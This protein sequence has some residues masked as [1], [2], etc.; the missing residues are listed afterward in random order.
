MTQDIAKVSADANYFTRIGAWLSER[1]PLANGI[2]SLVL[3]FAVAA[4]MQSGE[5]SLTAWTNWA[6]GM[7]LWGHFFVLRIFDEHKD[8]QTDLRNYPDRVIQSGVVKLREIRLLGYIVVALQIAYSEYRGGGLGFPLYAWAAMFGYT[9]LMGAEFFVGEWLQKRLLVY[10]ATHMLVMPLMAIW[11]CALAGAGGFDERVAVLALLF[12]CAGFAY[13]IFRKIRAPEQE[14]AG[15]DTYSSILGFRSASALA[16]AFTSGFLL[17]A[18]ALL[19]WA[20][21]PSAAAVALAIFLVLH[22]YLAYKLFAFCKQ[23]TAQGASGNE[24]LSG[25]YVVVLLGTLIAVCA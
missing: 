23:P 11:S 25:L 14:V 12:F 4:V 3:F 20:R 6:G 5:L 18:I 16:L 13:E 15:I 17:C 1:F 7:L 10:A 9:C 22:L 19:P 8:Y 2:L 24:K 21:Q